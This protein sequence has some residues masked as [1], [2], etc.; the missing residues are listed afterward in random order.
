MRTRFLGISVAN[1]NAMPE[2]LDMHVEYGGMVL[3]VASVDPDAGTAKLRPVADSGVAEC[4]EAFERFM[5][6]VGGKITEIG[7]EPQP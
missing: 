6:R 7:L 3:C 2:M 4:P 5:A 1:I